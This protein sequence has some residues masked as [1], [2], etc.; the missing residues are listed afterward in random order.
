MTL[1]TFRLILVLL[2]LAAIFWEGYGLASGHPGWT[3]SALVHD[4]RFDPVGRVIMIVF[5]TWL[6][7]HWFLNPKWLGTDTG[8]RDFVYLGVGSFLAYGDSVHWFHR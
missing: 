6:T 8:W 7:G 2:F 1:F 5:W 3:W 4:I